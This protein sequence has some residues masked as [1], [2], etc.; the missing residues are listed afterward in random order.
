MPESTYLD[1]HVNVGVDPA[2]PKADAYA[3]T[4][5]NVGVELPPEVTIIK[6]QVGW[7]VA[8]VPT[9]TTVHRP[10]DA[11]AH[12]ETLLNVGLA[13]ATPPEDAYLTTEVEVT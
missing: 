12:M 2:V 1:L 4:V 9:Y 10:T 6:P 11:E 13:L 7:G 5:L 8:V 3:E